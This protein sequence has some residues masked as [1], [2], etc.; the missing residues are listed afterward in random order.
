MT[1]KTS[2]L[3]KNRQVENQANI[4]NGM[5]FIRCSL[6]LT[7]IYKGDAILYYPS[8]DKIHPKIEGPYKYY[9]DSKYS[10]WISALN[11][12]F[13]KGWESRLAEGIRKTLK[14]FSR[15]K[16][17]R[18]MRRFAIPSWVVL[19]QLLQKLLMNQQNMTN[20]I[21]FNIIIYEDLINCNVFLLNGARF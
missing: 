4:Q 13:E 15:L 9:S 19:S 10:L 16:V 17:N 18:L 6:I 14:W 12:N 20:Q 11:L 3:N 2:Y 1:Q 7:F 5:T 8:P 21:N